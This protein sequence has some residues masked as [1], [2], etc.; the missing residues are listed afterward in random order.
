[1]WH[2][3]LEARDW[4]SGPTADVDMAH[5]P[6]VLPQAPV[7]YDQRYFDQLN[8]ILALHF[9]QLSGIVPVTAATLNIDI[10]LLPTQANLTTMR[11]GD[12]YRDTTA[13][14]LLKI[15]TGIYKS[16]V[17]RAVTIT[18]IAPTITVA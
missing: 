10:N 9:N 17:T 5:A 3:S 15:F 1:M 12:V 6:P 14:N 2:G 8:R 11:S 18:G 13:G 4:I 7:E 16:P